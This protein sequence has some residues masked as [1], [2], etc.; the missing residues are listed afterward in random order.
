MTRKIERETESKEQRGQ[1][2]HRGTDELTRERERQRKQKRA[3]HRG[4]QSE[5]ITERE[6]VCEGWGCD[7]CY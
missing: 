6:R 2:I 1:V 7:I 4:T 5:G 3:N